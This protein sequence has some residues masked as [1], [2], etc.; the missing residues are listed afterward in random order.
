MGALVCAS[1]TA[2]LTAVRAPIVHKPVL[3]GLPVPLSKPKAIDNPIFVPLLQTLMLPSVASRLS[4]R[5]STSGLQ[6]SLFLDRGD[7]NRTRKPTVKSIID[8]VKS[9]SGGQSS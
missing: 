4:A 6:E 9:F 1:M 5:W 3:K 2:W 7:Y 8:K